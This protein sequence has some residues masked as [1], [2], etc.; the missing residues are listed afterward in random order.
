MNPENPPCIPTCSVEFVFF[1]CGLYMFRGPIA[2]D[3]LWRL[4]ERDPRTY[5][6]REGGERDT[7][8]YTEVC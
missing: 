7:Y 5:R 2:T 1:V 8:G 3:W 4:R 6:E